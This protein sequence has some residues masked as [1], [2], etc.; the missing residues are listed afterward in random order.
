MYLIN[1]NNQIVFSNDTRQ[2]S[3]PLSETL[4][5]T[6]QGET[7][8]EN[9][10]LSKTLTSPLHDWELVKIT[11]REILFQEVRQTTYTSIIAGIVVGIL[12]LVMVGFITYKITNPIKRLTNK[13]S[14]IDGSY[15][16]V[17]FNDQ[18]HDEIGYLE[19]HMKDMM[20]RINLHIDREFKL[21][22]ENKENQFQALKSQVNPHFLFNALQSIGTVAIRSDDLN[23]YQ[24]ITY[25]SNMMIYSMQANKWLK[26]KDEMR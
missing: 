20:N 9:I 3:N 18:R 22:I 4:K 13:V 15:L 23:V 5:T 19:K 8:S 6:I 16:E 2:I 7:E 25:L 12:G 17:P 10:I 21:E 24:L 14:T 26:L 1:E 11:P